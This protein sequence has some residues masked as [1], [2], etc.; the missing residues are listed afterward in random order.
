MGSTWSIG[1]DGLTIHTTP[2]T[3]DIHLKNTTILSYNTAT[4]VIT[5]GSTTLDATVISAT[6]LSYLDGVTSA[7][8]TQMDLKAPKA[9][10]TFTGT[11]TIPTPFT[12]GATSVTASGSELNYVVGVTSAIQT[13]LN[14]L[15]P[16]ASPTF[17]GT[18]ASTP[19][20]AF[21]S[22]G[23]S[24]VPL[25]SRNIGLVTDGS[26]AE[27]SGTLAAGTI[28][29]EINVYV[30]AVGNAADSVRIVPSTLLGWASVKLA[31]N[32]LGKSATFLYTAQG[33]VVLASTGTLA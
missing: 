27:C 28:G 31:A 30:A 12:L 6:E 29:Q 22:S 9:S 19:A 10:P 15:A 3:I 4:G 13:Q 23:G 26:S 21:I 18:F 32:P 24:A 8:Q 11:V 14:L 33:W 2:S 20:S 16:K 7:I 1:S 5:L 25:T 17:T